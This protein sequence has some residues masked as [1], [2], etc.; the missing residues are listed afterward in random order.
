MK[1]QT[2][3]IGAFLVLISITV[4][5]SIYVSYNINH[6]HKNINELTERDFAGIAF[7][8][9]A[10]RDSYQSNLAISQIIN[11]KD[12]NKVA[13]LID[14][15]V[16]PNI[17]QV[18]ERFN[19]FKNLLEEIMP[20]NSQKFQE[21]EKEFNL[22]NEHT[23][24]LISM[25][26]SNEFEQA[27]EFY[28]NTYL[29]DYEKMRDLMDFFSEELYKI[30]NKE[31][32]QTD[33][34]IDNSLMSFIIITLL[35]III[36]IIFTVVLGKTIRNSINNFKDGLLG[37][38]RYLNR[39]D[40]SVELLDCSADDEISKIAEVV[41]E[42][43]SNTKSL[44]EKD[45]ILINDVKRVVELVKKGD[46]GKRIEKSSPNQGLN[47][48][49]TIFNEML[50]VISEHISNDI[51][52]IEGALKEYQNLNFK[53]RIVNATGNT[54]VGLNTLANI[55][56]EMLVE[57]KSNGLTL[58]KSSSELLSNVDNLSRSS[59][60]AAASIEE[61]AAALEEITSNIANNTQNVVE[62]ANNANELKKSANEGETMASQT[63]VAMDN[64][65]E[66]VEAINDAISI[67]DQIAFQTNILSLN[68]AVEAA[69]AGEA[70]KGFAVVAQ[71]VRNLASRSAEAA[72]E[73]KTL[74][75]NATHKANDGKAI[76]DKMISG[77]V[78]LN[79]NITKTLDLING[80]ES[81]SKEQQMGIEQINSAVGL[82]DRQT[83]ENA[84]IANQAKDIADQTQFIAD[85]I[86]KDANE[87][88]FEGKDSVKAK[89]IDLDNLKS[90]NTKE[91][92]KE[93][94]KEV[95]IERK[96]PTK[97]VSSE[98]KQ[99]EP[100][101]NKTSEPVKVIVPNNQDSDEWESF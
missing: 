90:K 44:I 17:K 86:I 60:E 18:G 101:K 100:L 88:E 96:E 91:E 71:E 81:S 24:K 95:V 48:L 47:E 80:V 26:N 99:E 54:V 36:A 94:I 79:E 29:N 9:E 19:K 78:S 33:D 4:I 32:T 61:T 69:T 43:I 34:L 42:N 37:F 8:L 31:E 66:Q 7:L 82:L 25:F 56:N 1:I 72:K 68:A 28:F 63:T 58:Q 45:E 41:N 52:T 46:I 93:S 62:M 76:S 10:D 2:K 53:H 30:I 39:E 6:I 73:I 22:T 77:Y 50:Q 38:F 59:N 67:I 74:V 27:Q 3:I 40:T 85:A 12:T 35:N 21:F 49:K 57:N 23:Q 70:G 87:K 11:L 83:Q 51:N 64:I 89:E 15:G 16:I 65:N 97:K 55:I 84:S 98:K 20:Q 92:Q 13:Q 5:S 14:N 75:E